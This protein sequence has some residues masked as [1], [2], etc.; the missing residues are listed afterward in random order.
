[1]ASKIKLGKILDEKKE[2]SRLLNH[3]STDGKNIYPEDSLTEQELMTK[4]FLEK[5]QQDDLVEAQREMDAARRQR[6]YK[7]KN[8]IQIQYEQ[9]KKRQMQPIGDDFQR[10]HR[11]AKNFYQNV[12]DD[13][14]R[15]HHFLQVDGNWDLTFHKMIYYSI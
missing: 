3:L 12:R 10:Q 7:K 1:M 5:K 14:E 8:E 15:V 9:S 4:L 13:L 11:E 6:S 2:R